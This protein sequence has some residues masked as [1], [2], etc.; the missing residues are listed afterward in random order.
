MLMGDG[1]LLPAVRKPANIHLLTAGGPGLYTVVMPSWCAGPHG[2]I[3]VHAEIAL[4]Q[5][6]AVPWA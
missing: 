4:N 5:A 2:N 6:C 1:D 3:A